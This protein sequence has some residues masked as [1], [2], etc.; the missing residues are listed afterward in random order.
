MVKF[1]VRMSTRI[2]IYPA[3]AVLPTN[4]FLPFVRMRQRVRAG[5]GP[6]G[7]A[8]AHGHAS[9]GKWSTR[10]RGRISVDAI[11]RPWEREF[12]EGKN[13]GCVYKRGSS[14]PFPSLPNNP[15]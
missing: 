1:T 7:P 4:G 13:Y 15:G 11:K 9:R 5:V 3:D 12:R 10:T 2:R 6:R 8:S 14:A